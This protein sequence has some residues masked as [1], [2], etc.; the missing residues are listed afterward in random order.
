MCQ[1][2]LEKV[3]LKKERI[4]PEFGKTG[5]IDVYVKR[6]FCGLVEKKA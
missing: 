3:K 1:V 4:D 5:I 2:L 6:G